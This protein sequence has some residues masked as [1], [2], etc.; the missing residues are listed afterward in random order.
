MVIRYWGNLHQ[1]FHRGDQPTTLEKD[2]L[3]RIIPE[4]VDWALPSVHHTII[5]GRMKLQQSFIL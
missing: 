5:V 3:G 1:S 2:V 4:V